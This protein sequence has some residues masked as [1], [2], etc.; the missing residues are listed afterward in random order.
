MYQE[1]KLKSPVAQLA[2]WRNPANRDGA[3]HIPEIVQYLESRER[4]GQRAYV[5]FRGVSDIMSHDAL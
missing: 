1:G 5:L 2:T 3:P 4:R